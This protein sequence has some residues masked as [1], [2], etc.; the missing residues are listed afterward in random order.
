MKARTIIDTFINVIWLIIFY[1]VYERFTLPF[2]SKADTL[3][4]ILSQS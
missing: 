3:N 4:G 1:Y 2:Y